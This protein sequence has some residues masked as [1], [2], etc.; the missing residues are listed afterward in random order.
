MGIVDLVIVCTV[1]VLAFIGLKIGVL[2]PVSGMGGI[3]MG[4]IVAFQIHSEVAVLLAG[5]IEGA[6]LRN[7]VAYAGIVLVVAGIS[8]LVAMLFRSFLSSIFARWMDHAA[9]AFGGALIGVAAVGTMV[10]LISGASVESTRNILDS[11]ILAPQITKASLLSASAPLCSS[12]LGQRAAGTECTSLTG[13]ISEL[14]GFDINAK[15]QS[16][17]GGQEAG[18]LMEITWAVLNGNPPAQ[19]ARLG[20][21][22]NLRY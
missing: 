9:G 17:S 19:L 7:V 11:S 1:G 14:T 21:T 13:L 12:P 22:E 2:K 18:P 10:F 4:A 8:R 3:V 5:Y 20:E 16:M 15:I 6:I